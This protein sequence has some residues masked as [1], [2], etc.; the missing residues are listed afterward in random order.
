M[1]KEIVWKKKSKHTMKLETYKG[2][3]TNQY[4]YNIYINRV[5]VSNEA[6]NLLTGGPHHHFDIYTIING[7]GDALA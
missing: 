6:L 3:I 1:K 7:L 5:G 2:V 4:L